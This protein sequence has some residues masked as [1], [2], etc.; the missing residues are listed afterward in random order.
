MI[1]KRKPVIGIAG[2]LILETVP[3][4]IGF[5]YE[6]TR[7][8]Y[9]LAIELA[10]GLP[11]YL[12]VTKNPSLI[13]DQANLC[14]GLLIPGGLDVN[15]LFYD[16]EPLP[17]LETTIPE[18]DAYQLKLIQEAYAHHLPML[19]VCRGHHILNV[20]F[21]G[22]LYQD[23]SYASPNPLQHHQITQLNQLA[24]TIQIYN[25]SILYE[26]FGEDLT[27]NSAHHQCV[28]A[29]GPDMFITA[30]APDGIIEGTQLSTRPFVIGVQWHPE[31]LIEPPVDTM[32]PLFRRFV[33]ATLYKN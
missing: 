4:V 23:V 18:T 16:E 25:D 9:A 14:D 5:K 1:M 24:H 32:L 10:G 7:N 26:L 12:P 3:P 29:L 22:T 27:V 20:A 13:A 28:Q 30:K 33:R 19:A 15:P 11:I 21:G 17:L 2:E 6:Y 31:M 8:N